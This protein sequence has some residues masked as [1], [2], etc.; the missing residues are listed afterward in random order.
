MFYTVFFVMVKVELD[1]DENKNLEIICK[2]LHNSTEPEKDEDL[3]EI[4]LHLKNNL[5][6]RIG[7]PTPA[8]G[9]FDF[10]LRYLPESFIFY[11]AD[12][13]LQIDTGNYEV[14]YYPTAHAML[15]VSKKDGGIH[16][17]TIDSRIVLFEDTGIKIETDNR[18]YWH[19][20][21]KAA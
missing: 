8:T 9:F 3:S 12:R 20:N 17:T 1:S 14:N 10:F 13:S 15:R 18:S 5:D 6:Q 19:P 2:T 4:L 21:T 7:Q 16:K 11:C